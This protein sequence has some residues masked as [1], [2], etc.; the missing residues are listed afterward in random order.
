MELNYN[1]PQMRHPEQKGLVSIICP[2]Y[3]TPEAWLRECLDSI[4]T[5]TFTNWEAILVNGSSTDKNVE[6]IL[7]EYAAKDQRFIVIEKENAGTLLARKTGLENSRGEFIANID[8]DDTYHPQF[9]EKMYEKIKQSNTDFV[10]CKS[11]YNDQSERYFI[12]GTDDFNF[13]SVK[14]IKTKGWYFTWNKLIRRNIYA[15]ILFPEKYFVT[16]EDFIQLIQITYHSKSAVFIS[17]NLYYHRPDGITYTRN[18]NAQVICEEAVKYAVV[19]HNIAIYLG[20]HIPYEYMRELYSGANACHYFSLQKKERETMKSDF[21]QL[22][23]KI[24]KYQKTGL[25]I[26]L[27]LASKGIEFPIKIREYIKT[28]F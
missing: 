24:I 6:H 9:L 1:L 10:W 17:E 12:A 11:Q 3:N 8:H 18:S 21:D 13:D 25:K 5:Q 14:F 4:L 2:I 20:V 26:C 7:G 22:L 27:F 19:M 15:K 28:L 23:P 16:Y